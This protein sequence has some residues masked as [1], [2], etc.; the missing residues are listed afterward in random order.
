LTPRGL[1]SGALNL[2]IFKWTQSTY[3]PRKC[4]PDPSTSFCYFEY[5]HTNGN[6]DTNYSTVKYN[7]I[8][9]SP[10]SATTLT[11]ILLYKVT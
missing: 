5:E 7:N 6:K 9:S 2:I 1:F 10:T 11:V 8:L 4:G 3:Q